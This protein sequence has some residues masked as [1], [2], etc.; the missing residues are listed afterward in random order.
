MAHSLIDGLTEDFDPT[1][2][3]DRYRDAL[4]GAVDQKIEGQ[5][6]KFL[7]GFVAFARAA[8]QGAVAAGA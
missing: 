6:Q 4:M 7:E 5:L 1:Q 2:F 8:R 3:R